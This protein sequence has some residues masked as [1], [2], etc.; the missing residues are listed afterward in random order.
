MN[1]AVDRT[2]WVYGRLTILRRGADKTRGVPM[3]VC[4][5]ACGAEVTV[6]SNSLRPGDATRSCGCYTRERMSQ[7]SRTHG[8]S[9][10]PLYSRWAHMMGRCCDPSH[11]QFSYYGGR[12]ISVAP[13]WQR[14][15][16]YIAD[17]ERE[18]GP[19][20]FPRASIDRINNDLGY[21]S[22]NVRWADPTLQA[23]NRRPRRSMP[24]INPE[25]GRF[26]SLPPV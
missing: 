16:R 11:K 19:S 24:P 26:V 7:Q 10:H 21:M 6:W 18:L 12:G 3:W 23:N 15:E 13:E 5:C 25:T 17:I 2:G 8:V 9:K 14:P 22:G 1:H 4:R 20:P